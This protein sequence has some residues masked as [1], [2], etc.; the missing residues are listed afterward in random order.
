MT[1]WTF[2]SGEFLLLRQALVVPDGVEITSVN[3]HGGWESMDLLVTRAQD[4]G[5]RVEHG[6]WLYDPSERYPHGWGIAWSHWDE[7]SGARMVISGPL[8]EF[9][10]DGGLVLEREASGA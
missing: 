4:A 5:G 9:N 10:A 1:T 7:P 2:H 6:I 8:F 3:L